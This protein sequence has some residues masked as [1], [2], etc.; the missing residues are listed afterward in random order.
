MYRCSIRERLTEKL[1]NCNGFFTTHRYPPFL[2]LR[3][4]QRIV[5]QFGQRREALINTDTRRFKIQTSDMVAPAPAG[6]RGKEYL[7]Y[8]ERIHLINGRSSRECMPTT[9]PFLSIVIRCTF[10]RCTKKNDHH[11]C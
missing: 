5:V 11:P 6:P 10:T 9:M 7:V 2:K 4:R 1:H 3:Q 8:F